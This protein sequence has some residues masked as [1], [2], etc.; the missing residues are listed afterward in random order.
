[1]TSQTENPT[2]QTINV[3]LDGLNYLSWT[4]FAMLY[5]KN[6]GKM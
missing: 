4:Q 5:I 3:K 6:R 1:V 2:L